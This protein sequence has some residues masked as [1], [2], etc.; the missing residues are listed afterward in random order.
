[1][2]KNIVLFRKLCYHKGEK[3]GMRQSAPNK[4]SLWLAERQAPI[5]QL[6]TYNEVASWF[7]VELDNIKTA[8]VIFLLPIAVLILRSNL[9]GR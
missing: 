7:F 9:A 8:I 6:A 4:N 5:S 3:N 1:L 2:G